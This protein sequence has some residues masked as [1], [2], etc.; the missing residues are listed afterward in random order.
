MSDQQQ[1]F[2]EWLADA[3][4]AD[5]KHAARDIAKRCCDFWSPADPLA[6]LRMAA[7]CGWLDLPYHGLDTLDHDRMTRAQR[8]AA[9]ALFP[10]CAATAGGRVNCAAVRCASVRRGKSTMATSAAPAP[11]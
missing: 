8:K 7:V 9:A 4:D 11:T 3:S 1:Q 5:C 10:A 6:M 2:A